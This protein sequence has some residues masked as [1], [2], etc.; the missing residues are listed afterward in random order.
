LIAYRRW[1]SLL[2]YLCVFLLTLLFGCA[3]LLRFPPSKP[4]SKEQTARLISH[5]KDQGEKI[6]SFQGVG[7]LRFKEGGE[8]SESNL[9]VVGC[10]PLKVRL[11]IT[12]PWGRPIS[13][14]VVDER[15]ISVLSLIDNKF[16]RGPSSPLNIE[17]LSPFGLD[18]ES[19]WK[20]LS[21]GVPILPHCRAVSLKPHEIILYNKRGEVVETISFFPGPLLPRSVSFPKKSITV[22]LS[23]FKERDVGPNPLRIKIEKGAEGQLVEIRYKDLRLN[24]AVPEG[25]FQLNPPPGFEIIHLDY[26]EK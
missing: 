14:I 15:D 26:Q 7:R 5:L 16:F 20:I 18:L 21:G 25:I 11:E 2:S 10:R 3:P 19:T 1:N 9:F 12:H 6:W 13:H 23:E 24:R 22:R 4:F 8:Q 17:R